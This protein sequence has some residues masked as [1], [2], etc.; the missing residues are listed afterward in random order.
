MG[1]G[2]VISHIEHHSERRKICLQQL[3]SGVR[4]LRSHARLLAL[5]IES[6]KPHTF[7]SRYFYI[8]HEK[9]AIIL[10]LS[11]SHPWCH[12]IL[13]SM[14]KQALEIDVTTRD[15]CVRCRYTHQIFN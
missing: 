4:E 13:A 11:E 6:L 9:K 2:I 8:S 12:V 3:G 5:E 15:I 10:L 7:K 14:I 1:G